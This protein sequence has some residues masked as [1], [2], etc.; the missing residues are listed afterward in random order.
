[1]REEIPLKEYLRLRPADLKKPAYRHVWLLLYWVIEVPLFFLTE[2]LPLTRHVIT[3]AL[4]DR[5]PFCE[6]W[7]VPYVLWFF[8]CVFVTVYTLLR[9]VPVFRRFLWY[10]IGTALVSFSFYLLWP[11]YFPGQPDPLPRQ[12]I[13]TWIVSLV[14]GSDEPTNVFPSE[15]VIVALGM[16]FATLHSRKLRRP[17]FAIPFIALQLLI[18]L[19]VVFVKQH[20]I[21][22][23]AGGAA[24]SLP[25]YF[26][27]F[28]PWKRRRCGGRY[29]ADA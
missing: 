3:C 2:K 19:S 15:H 28:F 8:C 6:Y 27:F 25:G 9:D 4:D 14:Y 24:L 16:V 10:L 5:I 7:I 20:S 29:P 23:V 17:A 1:M 13:F 12:N 18:C 21:L 26:V 22:D 11:S